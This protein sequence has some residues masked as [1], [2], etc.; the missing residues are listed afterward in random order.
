MSL[1]AGSSSLDSK[2]NVPPSFASVPLS[3][4]SV[5]E[6]LKVKSDVLLTLSNNLFELS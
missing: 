1:F 2:F 5:I 3:V 4:N 6:G